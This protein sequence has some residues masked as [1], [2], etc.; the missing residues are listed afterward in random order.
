MAVCC[1]PSVFTCFTSA[2]KNA[3][4]NTVNSLKNLLKISLIFPQYPQ[5]FLKFEIFPIL[6]KMSLKIFQSLF[7]FKFLSNFS[8]SFST[9]F[10]QILLSYHIDFLKIYLKLRSE[11]SNIS[12]KLHFEFNF[13]YIFLC[14]LQIFSYSPQISHKFSS[15]FP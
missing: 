4:E 12:Q 1:L 11:L 9:V 10:F 13:S 7:P 5:F 15:N 6:P 8:F 2:N 3:C 14:W